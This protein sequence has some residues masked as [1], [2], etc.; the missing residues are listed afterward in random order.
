MFAHQVPKTYIWIKTP[1]I[2]YSLKCHI[3]S[4]VLS[5][6]Q[7]HTYNVI[8]PTR[9]KKRHPAL[10]PIKHIICITEFSILFTHIN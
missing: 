3:V 6:S 8:F 1:K 10:G 7:L 4:D 9:N 5:F 2:V